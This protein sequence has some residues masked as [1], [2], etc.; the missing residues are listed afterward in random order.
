VIGSLFAGHLAQVA[1][2]SVLTRRREHAAALEADG[3]RVT[4]R[5]DLH[6]RV[7]ASSEPD[8]LPPAAATHPAAPVQSN[9]VAVETGRACPGMPGQVEDHTVR[10]SVLQ[11][12][13]AH[14]LGMIVLLEAWRAVGLELF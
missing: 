7:H 13:K 1:Q 3:L 11:L 4:G 8:E 9:S 6:A 10:P 5:S 12:E 2:V 14:C